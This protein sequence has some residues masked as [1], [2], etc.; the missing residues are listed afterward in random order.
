MPEVKDFL[1]AWKFQLGLQT[2]EPYQVTIRAKHIVIKRFRT[3]EFDIKMSF[4]SRTSVQSDD[5]NMFKKEM[6]EKVKGTPIVYSKYGNPYLCHMDSPI[7][8]VTRD[9]STGTISVRGH[10][11]PIFSSKVLQVQ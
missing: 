1:A 4:S 7:F 8:E 3:Y 2:I 5:W 9:H 10:A 11:V 6:I